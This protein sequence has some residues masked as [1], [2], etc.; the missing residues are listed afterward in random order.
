M[1]L[2]KTNAIVLRVIDYSETSCIVTLMT[3]DHGK[4]TAMAKGARRPKSPF[5][6]AL[7][8]LSVCRIVFLKKRSGAMDLLT[9]AR[10][11]RRFRAG[12]SSLERL[13]AGYYVA[14]LLNLLTDDA[15]PHPKLFDIA[16][17]TIDQID[18]V[19]TKTNNTSSIDETILDFELMALFCLGHLPLLTQCVGCGKE[20]TTLS[21]VSF[22]MNSGGILCQQC[23]PGK[24]NVIS[25]TSTGFAFLLDRTRQK[26]YLSHP[27]A[28]DPS[29]DSVQEPMTTDYNN[30]P[31]S[32]SF[33][34]RDLTT[35]SD[36]ISVEDPVPEVRSLL[37]NYIS[38][39]IGYQPRLQKF[40]N[41]SGRRTAASK[42]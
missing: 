39:L 40:L 38:H 27:F 11:E 28:N 16:I 3:R 37:R 30:R 25:L 6:A 4:I 29:A 21:R 31:E 19:K 5:E 17:E 18:S 32:S 36:P 41:N 34:A 12:A 35:A 13:Y 1:A 26:K 23:R 7:D 8:V 33:A 20:K 10:L 42:I 22:G 24:R 9:E 14:E 2:E 15:D